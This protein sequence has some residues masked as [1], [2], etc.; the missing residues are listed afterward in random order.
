VSHIE[1]IVAPSFLPSTAVLELTYACNHTCLFCSCP[2]EAPDTTV[3]REREMTTAE[4]TE[5]IHTLAAMGC[6]NIA[7]TGGEPLLR[8]DLDAL[9]DAAAVAQSPRIETVDGKLVRRQVAP[10]LY[11]LSNG[12]EMTPERLED[13]A[14]RGIQVSLSLPGLD[15]FP[16][17]TGGGDPDH[18][19]QCFRWGRELGMHIVANVTVTRQNL[20][21]LYQTISSAFLAGASQ[22][23]LNRFM[24]GGRGLLHTQALSLTAEEVREMLCAADAACVDADRPGDLGTEIPLCVTDGLHLKRLSVS[25]GCSAASEFF[26]VG[27]SGY[28]RACNHSPT[29]LTHVSSIED[30]KQHPHWRRFALHDHLPETPCGQCRQSTHCEGGCRAL[31]EVLYDDIS[32]PDPLLDHD[33]CI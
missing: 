10:S 22:L 29:R 32:A 4:W 8:T 31:A 3:P 1:G 19:L 26:V 17:L 28:V 18:V 6:S 16:A 9:L 2:W 25:S 7:F 11:L 20:E 5:A 21:E 27:P 30:L 12:R 24:P 15:A 33:T 14:R 13:L 23:L